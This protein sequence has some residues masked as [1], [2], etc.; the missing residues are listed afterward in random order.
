MRTVRQSTLTRGV[1]ILFLCMSLMLG[2]AIYFAHQALDDVISVAARQAESK[3][4]G[5]DLA[6]ASDFL[7]EQARR[8]SVTGDQ[9]DFQRYW[10]EIEVTKTRDRVLARLQELGTPKEELDLLATAK[11]NSD[12]LVTTETRSMRLRLEAAGVPESKMH[13]AV[14]AFH[15]SAEDAALGE[16]GKIQRSRTIMFDA[17][18]DRDKSIIVGPVA[19]FQ[20]RMNARLEH[21]AADAQH[22]AATALTVLTGLGI[23]FPVGIGFVLWAMHSSM[24]APVIR[25]IEV[26]RR[27]TAGDC[28]DDLVPAGT[29]ELRQLAEALNEQFHENQ[30]R[31][32]E[33]RIMVDSLTGVAQEVTSIAD[34]L[35]G[36]SEQLSQTT[37]QANQVVQQ[38]T[39]AIQQ[40]A[41]GAQE[42]ASTAQDTNRSV[43][44][45]MQAIDQVA[46]GAQAQVEAIATASATTGQMAARVD[47]VAASAQGVAEASRQTQAIADNGANAVRRTVLG[48]T[49]IQDAVAQARGRVEELGKLG[50]TIGSVVMTID[51]IAEQ[52]NLL[53]LNAAIEAA[54]AGEHGRGFAV[55]ADEVRKLAE[56]S[57]RET[58]AIS[59]L[60]RDVQVGTRQAVAA[61]EQGA[62]QVEDGSAQAASAGSALDEILTAVEATVRQVDEIAGAAQDMAARSREVTEMM[63]GMAASVEEASAAAEQMSASAEGVGRSI[64]S[65]A[66]VAEESSAA[67]EQVSASAEEMSA[68]VEEMNAQAEELAATAEQLK[69]LVATFASGDVSQPDPVVPLRRA[70]DWS[71]RA[72]AGRPRVHERAG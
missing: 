35:S 29:V 28:D 42:Q 43:E 7:T 25:Y 12:A 16:A 49:Q 44:Q 51:D 62:H 14:A 10:N 4:L 53:A 63:S 46:R 31:L 58:R 52:T 22:R 30:Q 5:A 65:I 8:F 41:S 56:R 18:Y 20:Q 37:G 11:A 32:S 54:R 40:V 57:Q 38:V 23:A 24:G 17:Q 55:V 21:A 50:E 67:T 47:Q 3:Q 64:G 72:Q 6:A 33:N 69:A 39:G 1:S 34:A 48:M 71:G 61:M 59:D 68:Q 26:L 36:A 2:G 45:L 60:I 27:R 13:P 19:E 70:E 66:A 9:A 15:L